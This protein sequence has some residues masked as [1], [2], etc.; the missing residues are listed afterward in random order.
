ML[1][2][3]I[4]Y[5]FER[6][7]M[8]K[9]VEETTSR[10]AD[11]SFP[12]HR[13]PPPLIAGLGYLI[14]SVGHCGGCLGGQSLHEHL[15]SRPL[16]IDDD[17]RPHPRS[18]GVKQLAVAGPIMGQNVLR[19]IPTGR[20]TAGRPHSVGG[21]IVLFMFSMGTA[22]PTALRGQILRGRSTL[23]PLSLMC[24]TALGLPAPLLL[25]AHSCCSSFANPR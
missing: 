23:R 21:P 4:L 18:S 13:P 24:T 6:N 9:Q 22:C 2:S 16:H 20:I 14:P 19:E 15:A 5:G 8:Q 12:T 7:E 1:S 3:A 17:C 25:S 10:T 11:F